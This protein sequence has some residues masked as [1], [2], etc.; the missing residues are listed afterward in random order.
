MELLSGRPLS[1][2]LQRVGRIPAIRALKIISH[3]CP[4]I[5]EAHDS[6]ILHRDIKPENIFLSE[7][8]G[9]DDSVK[10]LFSSVLKLDD[11]NSPKTRPGVIFGTPH[12]VSPEQGRG[13]KLGPPSDVYALGVVLY[14]MLMGRPPFD[15]KLP[16]EILIMHI[17]DE[18]PPLVGVPPPVAAVVM[19]ALAKD[20]SQ[21]QATCDQLFDECQDALAMLLGKLPTQGALPIIPVGGELGGDTR[22]YQAVA[23]Q[24]AAGMVAKL[25]F[26]DAYG[27]DAAVD[28]PSDGATLGRA[29]NNLIRSDDV[30][31]SRRHCRIVQAGGRWWVEDSSSSGTFVNDVRVQRQA[32]GHGDVIRCGSLQ[33]RFVEVPGILQPP[34]KSNPDQPTLSAGDIDIR[35]LAQMAPPAPAAPP[36]VIEEESSHRAV[37]LRSGQQAILGRTTGVDLQLEDITVSKR[38]AQVTHQGGFCVIEDLRSTGGTFVNE[39]RIAAPTPLKAGDR[40]RLG[41]LTLVVRPGA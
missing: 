15:S 36:F 27:R 33:V 13:S 25:V 31:V 40:I 41:R 16:T 28:I 24:A 38:H 26:R 10:V 32:L 20:P 6:G 17:R 7:G 9:G 19:K 34:V 4:V 3:V 21:R 5:G 2:E 18:P 30:A 39:Q 1:S 22:A 23:P 35:K 8:K 11:P 14:Q 37:T 12:Y 29:E